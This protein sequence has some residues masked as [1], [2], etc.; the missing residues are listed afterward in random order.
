MKRDNEKLQVITN[1]DELDLSLIT[2]DDVRPFA[3]FVIDAIREQRRQ[4]A[5]KKI[6]GEAVDI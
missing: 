4:E 5:L 1:A 2:E 6:R 3:Y